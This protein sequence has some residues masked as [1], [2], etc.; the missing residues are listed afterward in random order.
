MSVSEIASAIPGPEKARSGRLTNAYFVLTIVVLV[1]SF[2]TSFIRAA[3]DQGM[4]PVAIAG[5]RLWLA[6]FI[7]TPIVFR[8]YRAELRQMNRRDILLMA[9]V[10]VAFSAQIILIFVSVANATI[11]IAQVLFST[12]V[13]WT[14]ALERLF[15]KTA[16]TRLV[17]MGVA[18]A[19]IG[20]AI[21]G[22]ANRHEDNSST[23]ASDSAT[24]TEATTAPST[25]NLP[26]GLLAGLGGSATG[27]LYMVLSRKAREKTAL[28][29]YL[30]GIFGSG[31][32][33]ML[34]IMVITRTPV[35]GYN[36]EAYFW[37]LVMLIVAQFGIHG[38]L[39]Y[40]VRFLSA[41]FVFL[42]EQA[43][44]VTATIAAF[45]LFGEIP[46]VLE[47]VGGAVILAGVLLA[48]WGQQQSSEMESSPNPTHA[49]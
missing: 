43:T 24:V 16:F 10:G 48:I 36:R 35:I 38:G 37:L 30:W 47:V 27:A 13:L 28:I 23:T 2:S 21:I 11:M 31:A 42:A 45:F 3:L 19:F 12:I 20:G 7:L 8:R 32:I 41:T 49:E 46:K 44:A 40:V 25:R 17:L 33:L 6:W 4:T 22:V 1:D 26:L 5:L 14:A 18:L 15:L 34:A 9:V 29:P 39:N